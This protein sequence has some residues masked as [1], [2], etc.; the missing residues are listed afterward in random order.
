MLE[1]AYK[2]AYKRVFTVKKTL[3]PQT[4]KTALRVS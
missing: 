4:R 2:I 3:T 1:N